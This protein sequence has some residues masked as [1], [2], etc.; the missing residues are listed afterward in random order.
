MYWCTCC[1]KARECVFVSAKAL[2][3]R[4][5][6]CNERAGDAICCVSAAQ[7]APA[8]RCRG[9]D[10]H[11]RTC[12]RALF[13]SKRAGPPVETRLQIQANLQA[14]HDSPALSV[15][16]RCKAVTERRG[17][18]CWSENRPK[19]VHFLHSEYIG[20]HLLRVTPQMGTTVH[21]RTHQIGRQITLPAV[22]GGLCTLSHMA[23]GLA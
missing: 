23:S 12:T 1:Q 21:M 15:Y 22:L 17:V 13:G 11:Q 16:C 3:E 14:R 2:T 8:R 19:T 7:N 5:D 10:A 20:H 4:A 9:L 6:S 18:R